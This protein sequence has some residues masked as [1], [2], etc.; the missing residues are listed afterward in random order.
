MLQCQLSALCPG[1]R[2][3]FG[4]RQT[5]LICWVL[6]LG[7]DMLLHDF[8]QHPRGNSAAGLLATTNAALAQVIRDR[9]IALG[10]K[11][12]GNS[13]LVWGLRVG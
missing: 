10:G 8:L 4:S 9:H 6:L 12:A 3:C 5:T 13:P 1:V 7:W 2:C 11:G